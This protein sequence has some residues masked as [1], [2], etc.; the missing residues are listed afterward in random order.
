MAIFFVL[1]CFGF[2]CCFCC[3]FCLFLVVV[4]VVCCFFLSVPSQTGNRQVM[5]ICCL[6][7]ENVEMDVCI[8]PYAHLGKKVCAC[9]CRGRRGGGVGGAEWDGEGGQIFIGDGWGG[10]RHLINIRHLR[11]S[12]R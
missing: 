7:L 2:R 3:C 5:I 8:L 9:V 12:P 6:L 11:G 1:F 4:V 10:E